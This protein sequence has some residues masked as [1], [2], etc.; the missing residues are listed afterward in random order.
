MQF[1][2]HTNQLA[3]YTATQLNNFFPDGRSVSGADL[4]RYAAAGLERVERCFREIANPAYSEDGEAKFDV[5]HADQYCTY[6]YYLGN[7]MYREQGSCPL[8]NKLFY[9]NKALHSFNCMVEC[10]LPEVV[11]LL[12]PLGTVIVKGQYRNY[13]VVRQGCTIG[14]IGGV[15]PTIGE[16]FIMSAGSS[17]LGPCSIGEN[18]MLGVYSHVFKTD[19]P[20]DSI[21]VERNG[22][23]QLKPNSTRAISMHFHMGEAA[24]S[25]MDEEQ[26]PVRAAA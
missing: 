12:H 13:L 8:T 19:V 6:L 26:E 18:V 22:R 11:W 24:E 20:A 25:A 2:M 23:L 7:S 17:V 1:K 10:E 14:A 5:L 9:L 15:G 21:V 4:R 16:R 3:A